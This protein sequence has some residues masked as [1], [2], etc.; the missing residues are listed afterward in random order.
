MNQISRIHA[1]SIDNLSLSHSDQALIALDSGLDWIQ[2]RTKKMEFSARV[3]EAKKI[4]AICDRYNA[5][6]II[7]DSPE[8]VLESGADGVH[9]GQ[10]DTHPQIARGLL[11]PD[12]II[13]MTI[14]NKSEAQIGVDFYSEKWVDYA[15]VGPFRQTSTKTDLSAL[16]THQDLMEIA[17]CLNPI[18]IPYVVIGGVTPLDVEKIQSYGAFGIAV[19]GGLFAQNNIQKAVQEYKHFLSLAY[20]NE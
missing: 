3:L 17:A 9:L 15:G 12:K 1:I 18:K 2:F 16:L 13:G 10:K 14:H 11:G 8:V 5:I 7:N 4:K 6:L 20:K 19:A